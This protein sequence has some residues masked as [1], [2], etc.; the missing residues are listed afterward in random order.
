MSTADVVLRPVTGADLDLFEV[1]FATESGT[2]PWQWFGFTPTHGLRRRFAETGLLDA[3]G[4]VLT[5]EVDGVT[6]GRV[7][8][9]PASWGRPATSMCWTIAAGLRAAYR[10][11][12]I[13]TAAQRQLAEYLF[14]HTRAQRVQAFTDVSNVAEQRA[15]EKAGF[16]REG[17]IRSGQWRQ[18]EW[19]DQVL[20][21]ILR[22]P[23]Q[24]GPT[25]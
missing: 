22:Q 11:R 14:L 3:D 24:G 10:G 16:E 13:G 9:F 1:E 2:G 5:V 21:S 19:H 8:W 17:V 20:Y 6:V 18:G 12:G 15:L 4:G 7:E 25:A 23:A